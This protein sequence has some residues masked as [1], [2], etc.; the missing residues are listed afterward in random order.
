M[1]LVLAFE[2]GPYFSLSIARVNPLPHQLKAVCQYFM[3]LPRI[4][5]LPADDPGAGSMPTVGFAA[6]AWL[7]I[8][9]L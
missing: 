3:A 6:S 7:T 2:Y 8:E 4:R 1:S 9:R 5:F